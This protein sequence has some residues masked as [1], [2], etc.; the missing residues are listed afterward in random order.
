VKRDLRTYDEYVADARFELGS[1]RPEVENA[2]QEKREKQERYERGQELKR[3][4]RKIEKQLEEFSAKKDKMLKV[5]AD[6]PMDTTPDQARE[7]NTIETVL[8]HAETE[9]LRVSTELQGFE[10]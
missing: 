1:Q 10:A 9:W 7:F 4:L 2:M 8:A 5:F 6:K 3:E